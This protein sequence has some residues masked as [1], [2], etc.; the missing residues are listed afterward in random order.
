MKNELILNATPL[1]TAQSY[2]IN[3]LKINMEI[4]E[5][6]DF[7]NIQIKNANETTIKNIENIILKNKIGLEL[8]TNNALELTIPEHKT[9]KENIKIKINIK[10][11]K[12]ISKIKI[13]YEENSKA[14]IIV[15][16]IGNGFN[17][18]DIETNAKSY[19]NG[20]IIIANLL[21]EKAKSNIMAISNKL[22]ENAEISHIIVDFGAENKISNYY[23]ELK[24]FKAKNKLKTVYL[25]KNNDII[26]LNY[27]IKHFCEN[28]ISE[29]NVQGAIDNNS[30]KSFKGTIDFIKESKGSKGGENEN[31]VLLSDNAKSISLPMLL[32]HEDDVNGEHGVSSGKIDT[33]KLFYIMTKGISYEDARKLIIKANFNNIINEIPDEKLEQEVIEKIEK[34]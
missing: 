6:K 29:I 17:Y 26:D 33:K 18:L 3:D 9:I 5:I 31:C 27:N 1:R 25:G 15:K 4:S 24:G 2:Q 7:N 19:S 28:T 8:K 23:T 10:N 11:E 16:I 32:C 21:D 13:N 22:D 30:K 20:K 12:S 14:N 34:I